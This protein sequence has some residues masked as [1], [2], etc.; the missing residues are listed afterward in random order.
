MKNIISIL[1]FSALL[2]TACAPKD[3]EA[4]VLNSERDV[5]PICNMSIEHYQ[6]ATQIIYSN[7][8]YEIFDD[9]GCMIDY[10]HQKDSEQFEIMYVNDFETH[11]WI[12]AEE[13]YYLYSAEIWT[14][15]N[16]GIVGFQNKN[17]REH[18]SREYPTSEM[19]TF[20]DVLE[21]DFGGHH[22]SH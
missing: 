5:C 19:M 1:I 7:G 22:A 8:D 18:F 20:E 15:M 21:F 4:K 14:P 6:H 16:Y 13:A 9:I 2:L 17:D 12:D 3:F 10:Y 11:S